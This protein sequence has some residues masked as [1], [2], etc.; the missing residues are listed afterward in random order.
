MDPILGRLV[1][2]SVDAP[3]YDQSARARSLVHVSKSALALVHLYCSRGS[4]PTN[5]A[6]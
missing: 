3:L 1:G 5:E 6:E 4:E 2:E